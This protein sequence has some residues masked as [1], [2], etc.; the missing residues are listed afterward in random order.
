MLKHLSKIDI[1]TIIQLTGWSVVVAISLIW[2][3]SGQRR[4][5][6]ELARMVARTNIEKDILYRRWNTMHG[7]IYVLITPTTPPNP[8]LDPT[9]VS[10]RDITTTTGQQF[11]LMNPSY[12]TR[13]IYDMSQRDNL[14]AGHLT[15]LKP[16]RPENKPDQWEHSALQQFEQGKQ[17]ISGITMEDGKRYLRLMRPFVTEK[18]C[19]RCHSQQG[20][21]QGDIRGGI[22]VM[23]ALK[24]FEETTRQQIIA[25]CIGHGSLWLLGIGGILA[26]SKTI[27]RHEEELDQAAQELQKA[28]I[29]LEHQATTDS[30]TGISNRQKSTEFLNSEISRTLRYQTPLSLILFDIDHFKQI[31]DSHGHDAGDEVLKTLCS[32]VTAHVRTTDLFARW[33][34]EEFLI[35]CPET[36]IEDCLKLA[37]KLRGLV[38]TESLQPFGEIT[39]CSFGVAGFQAGDTAESLTKRADEAMYQAKKAGRNRVLN[40]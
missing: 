40:L 10:E 36:S 26:G 5:A 31:N 27:R 23:L 8:L 35:V 3:I 11:T 18:E 30:L 1:Y 25:S 32:L 33:G 22:S 34:G 12:M 9:I 14:T 21:K 7:G 15:S 28:N 19:L 38:E 39:T 24:P 2:S 16:I 29:L 20:Y 37:E 13:Q 6:Q 17:E 4:E